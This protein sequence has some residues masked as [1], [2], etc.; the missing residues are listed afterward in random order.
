MSVIVAPS[1]FHV[2]FELL[3]R[4][5]KL[6]G[7]NRAKPG[8]PAWRGDDGLRLKQRRAGD[9]DGDAR[10]HRAASIDDSPKD[11]AR[12]DLR[13]QWPRGQHCE[14]RQHAEPT[15]TRHEPSEN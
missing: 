5:P 9:G 8:S 3:P 7:R 15:H 14:T 2:W 13:G 10:Y 12:A 11:L 1:M 6:A 4:A